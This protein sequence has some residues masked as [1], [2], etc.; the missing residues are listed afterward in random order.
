MQPEVLWPLIQQAWELSHPGIVLHVAESEIPK[1]TGSSHASLV[2]AVTGVIKMASRA[3]ALI[4]TEGL[5]KGATNFM[6]NL[7]RKQQHR[8]DAPLI[9]VTSFMRVQ[10]HEQLEVNDD[11]CVYVDTEP[12]QDNKTEMLHPQHTHFVLGH[13]PSLTPAPTTSSLQLEEYIMK[14]TGAPQK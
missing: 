12:D 2:T 3:S 14:E 1:E 10:G 11:V 9:G 8:C 5:D 4:F 13:E 6:A 7:V